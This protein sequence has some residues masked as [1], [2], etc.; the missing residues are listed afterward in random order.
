MTAMMFEE[1][2]G[3]RLEEVKNQVIFSGDSPNDVPM[4][5]YFPNSVG[6]ANVKQF[7]GKMDHYPAWVTKKEGGYGFAEMVK[8]L[9]EGDRQNAKKH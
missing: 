5:A 2:Y 6:V 8:I 7:A 4:F 1:I 9:L 3:H